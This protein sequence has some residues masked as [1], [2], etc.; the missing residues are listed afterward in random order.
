MIDVTRRGSGT[1]RYAGDAWLSGAGAIVAA[2]GLLTAVAL[3]RSADIASYVASQPTRF[4][5]PDP[6]RTAR[7]DIA[8]TFDPSSAHYVPP[9]YAGFWLGMLVLA[10][11]LLMVAAGMS[12]A[13]AKRR[14]DRAARA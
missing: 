2:A 13:F 12:I 11:G 10:L 6:S 4:A 1:R 14:K 8:L 5:V 3:R 9:D 7:A